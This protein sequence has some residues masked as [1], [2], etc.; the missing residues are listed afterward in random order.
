MRRCPPGK[1][2]PVLIAFLIPLAVIVAAAVFMVARNHM[3][4]SAE[5]FDMA[6]YNR[7]ASDLQGNQYSLD[8]Q[9]DSQLRWDEGFGRYLAVKLVNGTGRLA[10]F[11]PDSVAS[12]VRPNQRYHMKIMVKDQGL[13]EAEEMQKY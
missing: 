11:V 13:I 9:I 3:H 2:N 8:A 6:A 10:V 4:H 7:S 12:E 5:P 1:V